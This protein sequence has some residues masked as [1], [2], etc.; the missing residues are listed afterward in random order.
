MSIEPMTLVLAE[1]DEGHANLVQR[2]LRRAGFVNAMV[3]VKD[4]QEALD[5]IR[6]EGAHASRTLSD[7]VLLL[8][9]INMPRIDG[10][11]VLRRIKNDPQTSKIPVIMLTTTDD[12]RE[13]ERCYDLGCSVYLTKPVEYEGFVEAINRLGLFLQ[14][15]KV[16]RNGGSH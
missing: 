12:P 10:I 11:E 15:V 8:L 4:G 1:D 13:V 5:Y 14:V 3:H 16:P 9:D 2:N 7:W 6:G